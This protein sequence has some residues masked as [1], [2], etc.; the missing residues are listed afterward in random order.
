MPTRVS[1]AAKRL[2]EVLEV[3]GRFEVAG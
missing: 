1:V 3:L 2:D